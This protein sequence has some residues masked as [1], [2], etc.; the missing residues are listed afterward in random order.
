[1]NPRM[2]IQTGTTTYEVF[3]TRLP[4]TVLSGFLGAGKT[5]L[6][7]HILANREGKKVAVIVNDM[8]EINID[9]QLVTQGNAALSRT[10]E[11]LVEMTNGCICCTLRE[12]LLTEVRQLA[13]QNRFDYLLIEST[14]ISEPL[15]IAETFTFE[16]EHGVSLSQ[17]AKLDTMVTVV[18]AF[19]FLQDYVESQDLKD[20]N[21]AL[22]PDDDRTITDLLVDQIEFAD[23][24]VL[25]KT[26]LVEPEELV[27][28]EGII[29]HL[30][31]EARIIHGVKSQVKLDEVLGTNRFSFERASQS[32]GWLKE[33][34]G[35]H[36]PETEAYG[37]RS[38]VFRAQRPMHPER[39]WEFVKRSLDEGVIRAKGFLWLASRH[40]DMGIWS[41]AGRSMMLSF[42]GNWF[43]E[44]PENEWPTDALA[45][46]SIRENWHPKWG[47]RHQEL[48]FIGMQ[49]DT[50]KL[51]SDLERC[52]LTPEEEQSDVETWRNFYDPLPQWQFE[53][54][55]TPSVD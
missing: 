33:L 9:G 3:M 27:R 54:D 4:V 55:M 40:S 13:S 6:L 48:V 18:D 21:L 20:R 32:A 30:N 53:D 26:D 25:N 23:V 22:G 29:H 1:M 35:E 44:V 37:I 41:Q 47:D 42:G 2:S 36:V 7:N 45:R 52:L 10:D 17:V 28:V 43:A 51:H 49:I 14:G 39:F 31:P 12:D 50:R 11:R 38:F 15:P 24:V 16:D 46:E 8:N 5:T 34:R 19:N